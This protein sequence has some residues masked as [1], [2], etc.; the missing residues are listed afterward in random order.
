MMAVLVFCILGIVTDIKL[1][2][3]A[4]LRTL[5]KMYTFGVLVWKG[6]LWKRFVP[7]AN[8][9]IYFKFIYQNEF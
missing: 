7:Q 9:F 6:Y 4:L 1:F 5:L 8:I 2:V 3:L